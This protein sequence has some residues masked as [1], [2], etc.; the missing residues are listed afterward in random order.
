[1]RCPEP[2][3]A[4]SAR[5]SWRPRALMLLSAADKSSKAIDKLAEEKEKILTQ[6]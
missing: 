1:L 5:V 4:D 3:G 2:A 6:V